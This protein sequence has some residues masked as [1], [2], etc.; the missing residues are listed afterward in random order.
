MLRQRVPSLHAI[1]LHEQGYR[2]LVLLELSLV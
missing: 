1:S 2:D